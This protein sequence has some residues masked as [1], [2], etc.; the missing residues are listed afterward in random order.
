M[1][2]LFLLCGL[3]ETAFSSASE[4]LGPTF[5]P[6]NEIPEGKAVVYIY[7]SDNFAQVYIVRAN[8][9]N[10]INLRSSSYF[11]FVCAPGSIQF[12]AKVKFKFGSTGLLNKAW[13]AE[14][15]IQLEIKEGKVYYLKGFP[16]YSPELTQR[17]E[18]IELDPEEAIA[19]IQH[20]HLA[21]SN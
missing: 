20:T 6:V 9:Q 13:S 2:A 4:K 15:S 18:L 5:E 16:S 14:K 12:T 21:P 17:M 1:I 7:R 11:P 3:I 10:L 8:G 19:E